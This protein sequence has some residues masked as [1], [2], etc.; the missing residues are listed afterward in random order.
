MIDVKNRSFHPLMMEQIV[1]EDLPVEKP[2][3]TQVK[4]SEKS[5]R[6]VAQKEV[7]IASCERC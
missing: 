5:L 7:A 6:E 2:T 4:L 3:V 1:K